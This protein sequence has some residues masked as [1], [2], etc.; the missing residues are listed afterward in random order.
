M[1]TNIDIISI[2]FLISSLYSS[3]LIDNKDI[4]SYMSDI[5]DQSSTSNKFNEMIQKIFTLDIKTGEG[6]I[7]DNTNGTANLTKFEYILELLISFL[8]QIKNIINNIE[9]YKEKFKTLTTIIITSISISGAEIANTKADA[10]AA[11]PDPTTITLPTIRTSDYNA[12]GRTYGYNG[13]T[14]FKEYN[15]STPKNLTIVQNDLN[16]NTNWEKILEY[17]AYYILNMTQ[18]NAKVQIHALV[19]YYKLVQYYFKVYKYSEELIFRTSLTYTAAAGLTPEQ[20]TLVT[21]CNYLEINLTDLI[22]NINEYVTVETSSSENENIKKSGRIFKVKNITN[23]IIISV[24]GTPALTDTFKIYDNYDN[25]VFKYNYTQNSKDYTLKIPI[26][27]VIIESGVITKIILDDKYFKLPLKMAELDKDIS[28]N[29]ATGQYPITVNSISIVDKDLYSLKSEYLLTGKELKK[30]N[31]N[32]E[33]YRKDINDTVSKFNIN[34]NKN[35]ILNIQINIYYCIYGIIIF[36]LIG[37]NLYQFT[38]NIKQI[39]SLIVIVIIIILILINYYIQNKY[40]EEFKENFFTTLTCKGL[41]TNESIANKVT[42]INNYINTFVPNTKVYLNN[43]MAYLPL[44]DSY[45]LYKK[46]SKSMKKEKKDFNNIEKEY[47]NKNI[48]AI[49]NTS[50]MRDEIINKSAYI[51]LISYTFLIISLL[52]L[53]YLLIPDYIKLSVFIGLLLFIIIMWIYI[54]NIKETV[55]RNSNNKYWIKPSENILN[56]LKRIS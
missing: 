34:S 45:D 14:T 15:K 23:P 8:S 1:A 38:N 5:T 17:H 47:Y 2:K 28:V 6:L 12:S 39:I 21:L 29:D 10:S 33:K 27:N 43:L 53:S 7:L 31:E 40:I 26:I 48:N 37:L 51:N 49:E 56:E 3:C 24:E 13:S 20:G 55:R 18:D 4:F 30:N 41:K 46:L 50:M 16:N 22:N 32:I 35:D 42:Y 52:Y 36:I 54:Y 9:N 11:F 44:L 25:Y 19:G